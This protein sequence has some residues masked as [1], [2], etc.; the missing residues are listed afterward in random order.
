MQREDTAEPER[1]QPSPA[2]TNRLHRSLGST[3]PAME[4]VLSRTLAD[5]LR[6]ATLGPGCGTERQF[7]CE[8][9]FA[10]HRRLDLHTQDTL[11]LPKPATITKRSSSDRQDIRKIAFGRSALPEF[12]PPC[13]IAVP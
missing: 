3:G 7:F 11:S 4:R 10:S 13:A 8:S 2:G 12:N 9:Q 1:C 5:V 6:T